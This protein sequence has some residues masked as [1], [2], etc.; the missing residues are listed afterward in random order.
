MFRFKISLY[1]Q[2]FGE[3]APILTIWCFSNGLVQLQSLQILPKFRQKVSF[4]SS[5]Q[6]NFME[7]PTS[8]G[9]HATI[10][11]T[12]QWRVWKQ[13]S[14]AA[15]GCWRGVFAPLTLNGTLLVDG[16]LCSC[17]SP[18]QEC[19]SC[20][21]VGL[22]GYFVLNIMQREDGYIVT[23]CFLN[24]FHQVNLKVFHGNMDTSIKLS[25]W[26]IH[27]YQWH[28]GVP[29]VPCFSSGP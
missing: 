1:T 18:P 20:R 28:P 21:R 8:Y 26:A 9:T 25:N 13:T 12:W 11:L 17:F 14:S 29:G 3:D 4:R 15:S 24:I 27:P 5:H 10:I 16:I 2:I 19:V 6:W 22:E 23:S 7:S